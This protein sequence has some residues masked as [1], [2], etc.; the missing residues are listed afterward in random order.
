M[1]T[2]EVRPVRS[3]ADR[4]TFLRFPW[5]ISRGDRLWV[6]PL[7]PE[8]RRVIDPQRGTFF[9]RGTAEFFIAWREGKPVGTICA[10]IDPK[11]NQAAGRNDCLFGFFEF[12]NNIVE[13]FF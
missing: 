12:I 3:A 13:C 7:L 9:K 5:R 6:P 10:A 2:V 1:S 4:R 11:T 8:R